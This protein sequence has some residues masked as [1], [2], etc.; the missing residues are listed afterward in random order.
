MEEMVAKFNNGRGKEVNIQIEYTVYGADYFQ[1]LDVAINAGEEP[2]IF[3]PSEN[4]PQLIM[5]G[6]L[7]PWTEIPGIEDI[8]KNQEPFHIRNS[9]IYNGVIYSVMQSQSVMGLHYN[10]ELLSRAGFSAPPK[11]WKEFEDACIAISKLEPGRKFGYAIPLQFVGFPDWML[12]AGIVGSTGHFFYDFTNAKYNFSDSAPYFESLR[13]IVEGGGM[14]PGIEGLDDDQMRA[15]FAEGNL[16][17]I[18]GGSWNV[19]VFYDQFPSKVDWDVAPMPVRDPGRVYNSLANA[20][21]AYSVST[22]V[23]TSGLQAA[24]GEVIRVLCG[25]ETQIL[26]YSRAKDLPARQDIVARATPPTRYQW[27]SFIV[28]NPN[29]VPKPQMPHNFLPLEGLP[30]R[31]IFAQ[32]ITGMAPIESSLADLDRRY[33]AALEKAFSSGTINRADFTDPSIEQKFRAGR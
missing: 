22:K 31:P 6:R 16:G 9:T 24:V 12:E 27:N 23:R 7:L 29:A 33:N 21:A 10:K 8:L 32:I 15:Q 1:A 11:T 2:E 18:G 20:G 5:A 26:L 19:G 30:Y 14:F 4:T 17:F 25:D 3:V 28:G 13:R